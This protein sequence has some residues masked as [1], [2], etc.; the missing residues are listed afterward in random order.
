MRGLWIL[1]ATLLA[2]AASMLP[3]AAD[4]RVAMVIGNSAYEHVG[5][6]A[7]PVT[8]SR[9]LREVLK[10]IGFDEPNIIYGENL[11]KREFERA[12]GRFAVL[13][14]DADVALAYYAGHGATFGD[15]PYIVPVDARFDSVDQMAYELVPLE[16]MIGE[17]RRAKGV[18]I[19]IVDA[20]RDNGAEKDL[21]RTEARW[22]W[23]T[24]CR[25]GA[26]P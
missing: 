21:K 1:L 17:L 10:K 18:R 7:N 19:A 3:A 8:N 26:K 14:R 2:L 12:I 13:A 4:R 22:R 9:N 23:S 20:C 15:T 5:Q 25:V 11:N 24:H 6:L 16:S